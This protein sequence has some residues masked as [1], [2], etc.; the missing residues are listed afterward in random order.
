M[1]LS[2]SNSRIWNFEQYSGQVFAV[3]DNGKAYTYGELFQQGEL[4]A[5]AVLSQRSLVFILC[6]NTVGS[7]LGYTACLN[8]GSVAVLVDAGLDSVLLKN[9]LQTYSPNFVWLPSDHQICMAGGNEIYGAWGYSMLQWNASAIELN[10]DLALL[11]TTSGST[12]SPKLVRQSRRNILANTRSIVQYLGIDASERPITT[13]PMNYTYGLSIINTHL[14]MGATL[15]LTQYGIMQREF[16]QR[17][18]S[19]EVTSIA[20]V[21]YIYEMLDRLRFTRMQLPSLKTLTQAGGKLSVKLHEKFAMYAQEQ[22]KRFIVMYGQTEAT[23]RMGYLPPEYALSKI[24]SMGKAIPGGEFALV[25]VDGKEITEPETVGEL[26][27]RGDNVTMGYA[28]CQADLA[29]ADERNGVLATGDMAKR[30]QDGF[31]YIV[32]RKKRFLK[33][34]G[35][36]VNLDET[37]RLLATN[38]ENLDCACSG[39]DDKL[40]VFITDSTRQAEVERFLPEKLGFHPSAFAVIVIPK[41]PRNDAGKILYTQLDG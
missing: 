30:D 10:P 20:G 38:F 26:I 9:L 22:N 36:R 12:G 2:F 23:A 8:H 19:D 39:V 37:E 34:F 24:G 6:T 27:Y 29:K 11:L 14:F 1:M 41:I 33:I 31:Y 15:I 21:P 25:D 18:K 40:K 3:D 7:I 4:L 13:L 16:W 17:M 5:S 35:S 28:E 32:G